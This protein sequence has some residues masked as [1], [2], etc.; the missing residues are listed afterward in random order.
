[1][2]ID[3][4]NDAKEALVLLTEEFNVV[5]LSENEDELFITACSIVVIEAASEE[6]SMNMA[7]AEIDAILCAS[8]ELA[9]VNAK[10]VL[11]TAADKELLNVKKARRQRCGSRRQRRT[12]RNKYS[13]YIGY[14]CSN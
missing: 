7:L 14:R 1:V 10:S 11:V 8:E 6:L 12:C 2:S 3:T 5:N 13:I 4:I 9:F